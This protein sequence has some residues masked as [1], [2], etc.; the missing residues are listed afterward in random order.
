[1]QRKHVFFDLQNIYPKN[2][3]TDE[4]IRTGQIQMNLKD[5]SYRKGSENSTPSGMTNKVEGWQKIY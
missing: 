5:I 2:M 4:A 3:R 1:M